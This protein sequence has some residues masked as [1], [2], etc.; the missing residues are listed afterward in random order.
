MN[1]VLLFCERMDLES[2]NAGTKARGILVFLRSCFPDCLSPAA[3]LSLFTLFLHVPLRAERLDFSTRILPVLTKAGCNSGGCHGAATGQGGFKLSLLGFD[4]EQDHL[5]LTRELGARRI[6]WAAP[7]ESLFLKK[8][9]RQIEHEGERRFSRD[10]AEAA[11]LERWV[12]AGAPFGPK[13]LRV[14]GLKVEPTTVVA[15]SD[16]AVQL[17]V[18]AE[19]SDGTREDVT[20][21]ALYSSNDDAVADV[22]KRGVVQVRGSGS[23]GIMVRYAGQV[24]A[25]LVDRPFEGPDNRAAFAKFAQQNFVDELVLTRLQRLRVPPSPLADDA[26]FLRRASLDLA[27]R[28]P[29]PEEIQTFLAQ[30]ESAPKRRQVIDRLLRSEEFTDLWTM[31]VADL[32]LLSGRRGNEAGTTA[33][34]RWLREQLARNRPWNETIRALVTAAGSIAEVGPANFLSLVNDPRDLAEHV[35]TMFLGTQIGCARCHAHPSDRWTQGDYHQ[36]AAYFAQV[37]RDGGT[38]R[39]GERGEVEH[40]KTGRAVVPKPLGSEATRTDRTRSRRTELADWLGAPDNPLFAR[41]LVNRIW[42]HLLGRGLVEPV[43]DLRLTNPASNP[44]LLDALAAHFVASGFDLRDLVRTITQSR[45]YQ[46]ASQ[47]VPGNEQDDRFHSHALLKT[48]SAQ[49]LL[50][51]I[52]QATGVPEQFAGQNEPTRAVQLVGVQT[53]SHA[54][55]VLGRCARER[56]CET[57]SISGGGLAQALHLINGSTINHRLNQGLLARI[58]NERL[59]DEAAVRTLYLHTL[60][61]PPTPAEASEWKSL[62]A[63][64]PKRTEALEDLLWALLN[65]REFVFNH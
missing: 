38:V 58:Q 10:S 3:W 45:T 23:T 59:P 9:T 6:D 7:A 28:L 36:F 1:A 41:S 32:L 14:V 48:P 39:D 47:T 35:G 61:R 44:A 25:T 50:D 31:R 49:V 30:P 16:E 52:A 34:H 26:T 29:T 12:A 11:L 4:P 17:R 60:S 63:S 20:A 37:T 51:V 62:M 57:T 15:A 64:T 40:P 53:P 18:T 21:L 19:L 43:D 46:L 27:G 33:Y 5:A 42:K 65:S 8:A 55:D 2:R 24:A 54:L 13:E 22:T 56:S